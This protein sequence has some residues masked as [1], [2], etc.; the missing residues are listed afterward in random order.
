MRSKARQIILGLA[1]YTLSLM[2]SS[3]TWFQISMDP[4]DT[5]VLL[6]EFSGVQA[7][8]YITAI[9]TLA[10]ATLVIASLLPK[11]GRISMIS[12]S[13]FATL[14]GA[15]LVFLGIRDQDLKNLAKDIE[16]A[17]GIAAA[18][19]LSEFQISTLPVAG[20]SCLALI[21]SG[22]YLA[23]MA[24]FSWNWKKKGTRATST[25]AFKKPSDAISLWDQQR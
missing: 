8:P 18:H 23:A 15:L 4:G 5:S 2:L 10:L 19:G 7:F 12:L 13:S 6:L 3:Q 9:A 16:T 20:F 17:T 11:I 14:T 24:Y 21:G 1:L 22:I 25:Q